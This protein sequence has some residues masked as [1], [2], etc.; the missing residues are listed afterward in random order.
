MAR[1]GLFVVLALAG[2]VAVPPLRADDK[3]KHPA[4]RLARETSPY[5]LQHAHNPVDW[6]P[7]GPEAFEKA[8]TEGKPIFLSVGYSSCYWCHVM[9]RESFEDAA[10]AK[11][12]NEKFVCIKVDREERPDVDGVYMAALQTF[13][14]SGGWPM[15]LFLFPDGRPFFAATYLPPRDIDEREGFATILARVSEAWRDHRADLSKDAD[16]LT[17]A[18]RTSARAVAA[19]ARVPLKRSML[20]DGQAALAEQFDPDFG[21]FGYDVKKPRKPKFP[22]PSNLVFLL[23]RDRKPGTEPKRF[24]LVD[25]EGKLKGPDPK[26]MA[27][28][29]LDR[30][31][32]GGIR[33]HLAGGYHRYSTNRSW[34][35]PH[36]E[37]MLYDNAQLASVHL[38]AYEATKD[39]RWKREAEATFAFLKRTMTSP[40]GAFYSALDA[41]TDGNEGAYYVWTEAEVEKVLGKGEDFDLFYK[42]YGLDRGPNFEDDRFV[43]RETR[44]RE[45]LAKALDT[46]PDDLEKRLA[47]MRAR[48]LA[49]REKRPA[50][51][52]DDKILTSWNA[53]AIAAYADG[54]RV[55]KDPA[56]RTTAETAA[57]FLLK[58]H[59][60]KDG[61]LLRTSRGAAAKGAAY[62][63]DYAFLAHALL[64]LHAATGDA[65]RL[66]QARD[67]TDRM[68]A[69]FSDAD[70]GF[71]FTADSGESLL[72][73]MKDPF[74]NALPGPNNVAIRNLVALYGLTKESKYLTAAGKALDAFSPALA[75]MPAAV[76][77]ML[78]GLDEYLDARGDNAPIPA[79][80]AIP[81]L[82]AKTVLSAV[83]SPAPGSK[84]APGSEI[85]VILT[86]TL[87]D[88]WHIYANPNGSEVVKPT[89]LELS[90][91]SS[92]TLLKVDY[93]RG[94]SMASPGGAGEKVDVYDG[95]TMIKA[96]VRLDAR[97][98]TDLEFLVRYQPCN[99]RA[100][101]APAKLK[102]SLKADGRSP[103]GVPK[104]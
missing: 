93:P 71:F 101:L 81:G 73:R 36:F 99:D 20:V 22:E 57:D 32:R 50:P 42:T 70:G 83:A 53:L 65:T 51:R 12:L 9:E 37:K 4:N 33:D 29:T 25:R 87:Q 68:L 66:A 95:K 14:G 43:L 24:T 7:W 82:P 40:Q 41:E 102:V 8:K 59:R 80:G 28:V 27:L 15:S 48:L 74:D 86:L 26:T 10:I 103:S 92:A 89:V 11:A 90:P 72:A 16:S 100:C 60:D 35:I 85:D 55:L 13:S 52:L 67:L 17:E 62:L 1:N 64:R 45:E 31:A 6:F 58:T 76:P 61:R 84:I 30:M 91:E 97:A 54:F 78:V 19:K 75:E 47:P 2:L 104:P 77:L 18:V 88:G 69:E 34:T 3:P 98:S 5:L 38:T 63:E 56:Y 21:G 79:S 49:V 23:H 96:R 39:E 44:P 46:T 94:K